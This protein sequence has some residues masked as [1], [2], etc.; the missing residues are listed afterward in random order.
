MPRPAARHPISSH[1]TRAAAAAAA[2]QSPKTAAAPRKSA[3][4]SPTRP[5]TA[6]PR[7]AAPLAGLTELVGDV[8]TLL[9]G[10]AGTEAGVMLEEEDAPPL[11][12]A[13]VSVEVP[14]A[15]V[16]SVVETGT[17]VVEVELGATVVE[18]V[19]EVSEDV[20]ETETEA[21]VEADTARPL[22]GLGKSLCEAELEACSNRARN[23]NA[24][25]SV[26]TSK[27][28]VRGR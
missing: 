25:S 20:V 3:A 16:E 21:E 12:P 7:S 13:T 9:L 19:T 28:F 17:M 27:V 8:P 11:A 10:A 23:M 1:R 18:V 14:G 6:A 15:P 4:A 26:G 24:F 2:G 5:S 22:A